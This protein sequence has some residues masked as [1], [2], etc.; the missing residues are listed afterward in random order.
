VEAAAADL[1]VNHG[2]GYSGS[3]GEVL[4][5]LLKGKNGP[6]ARAFALD[7][8]AFTAFAAAHPRSKPKPGE[9]PSAEQVAAD[10][11]SYKEEGY[12]P[13][14]DGNVAPPTANPADSGRP[15]PP[16][17]SR[18]GPVVKPSPTPAAGTPVEGRPP[19]T[20]GASTTDLCENAARGLGDAAGGS[21][22][23]RKYAVA[24]LAGEVKGS[25]GP[26]HRP[27]QADHPLS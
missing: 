9:K 10:A 4:D 13:G 21:V 25:P 3:K 2:L 16:D 6:A 1:L 18:V 11:A 12:R 14:P 19:G 26:L 27:V 17:D 24:G 8:I 23:D 7:A 15:K 5:D 22:P 20:G